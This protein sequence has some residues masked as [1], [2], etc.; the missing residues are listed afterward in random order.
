MKK[1]I[2]LLALISTFGIASAKKIYCEA[3]F[4]KKDFF[5]LSRKVRMEVDYGQEQKLTTNR[6][7]VRKSTG[8]SFIFNSCIDA[9]NYMGTLGWE[10]EFV[11][12][13]GNVYRFLFSK[14]ATFSEV[15]NEFCTL[16]EYKNKGGK[17]SNLIIKNSS[18]NIVNIS[19]KIK[20]ILQKN[21]NSILVDLSN[22]GLEKYEI[23]YVSLI[24]DTITFTKTDPFKNKYYDIIPTSLL[25]RQA[26]YEY[27][28]ETYN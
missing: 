28:I 17:N 20:E 14:E 10:L 6:F 1:L 5:G 27:I 12:P 19:L 11:F 13:V 23:S 25:D 21:N 18:N 15:E 24:N 7:L 9:L 3:V 8:Q 26:I 2:L 4:Y 22:I 16:S